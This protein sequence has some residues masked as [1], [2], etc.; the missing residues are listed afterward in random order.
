MLVPGYRPPK[1]TNEPPPFRDF[2]AHRYDMARLTAM[3]ERLIAVTAHAEPNG[4]TVAVPVPAVEKLYRGKGL[5]RL[6]ASV[7]RAIGSG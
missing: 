5:T 6:R 4:I 2:D 7:A 1:P 3:I